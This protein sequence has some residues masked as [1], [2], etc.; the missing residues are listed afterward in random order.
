MGSHRVGHDWMTEPYTHTHFWTLHQWNHIVPNNLFLPSFSQWYA[1]KILVGIDSLTVLYSNNYSN[2]II[3]ICYTWCS[4]STVEGHLSCFSF[5]LFQIMTPETFL[6]QWCA[7]LSA[8]P[9][10]VYTGE[11][12]L[13]HGIYSVFVV[14][15]KKFFQSDYMNLHSH[16]QF[17]RFIHILANTMLSSFL[18]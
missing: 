2:S 18:F 5:G 13:G 7:H 14:T 16:R 6:Y 15:V 8:L 4:L 9:L 12:L 17:M 3:W 11:E 1:C 10:S